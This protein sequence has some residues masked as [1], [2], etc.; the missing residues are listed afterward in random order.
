[1]SENSQFTE[2][3][4][5]SNSRIKLQKNLSQK[6]SSSSS[7]SS[8]S[9]SEAKIN[10]ATSATATLHGNGIPEKTRLHGL[11]PAKPPVSPPGSHQIIAVS[12]LGGMRLDS[13]HSPHAGRSF[14][15]RR[16]LL[17]FATLSSMG[18]I[19]LIYLTLSMRKDLN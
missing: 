7:T 13:P 18:T 2:K 14:T 3:E 8:N 1:M 6:R 4:D 9:V 10:L 11:G 16:I 19:V 15:P 5:S 12:T 17:C